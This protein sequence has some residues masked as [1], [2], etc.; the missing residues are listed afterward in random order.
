[1]YYIDM[2]S[3]LLSIMVA[4]LNK[5]MAICFDSEMICVDLKYKVKLSCRSPID[6]KNKLTMEGVVND[7]LL[8]RRCTISMSD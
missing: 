3:I 7:N 6:I 5:H 2:Y 1:M 4:F 8:E